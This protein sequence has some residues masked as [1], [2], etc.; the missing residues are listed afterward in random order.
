MIILG[1]RTNSL[2]MN[3]PIGISVGVLKSAGIAAAAP[4]IGRPKVPAATSTTSPGGASTSLFPT[5]TVMVPETQRRI[6]ISPGW[7][8]GPV[9]LIPGPPPGGVVAMTR[10]RS[11]VVSAVVTPLLLVEAI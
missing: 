1:Y 5:S 6:S 11:P 9:L 2:D 3:S 4:D 7:R 8:C 10:Y